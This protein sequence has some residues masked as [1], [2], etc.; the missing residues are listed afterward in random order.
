MA[1]GSRGI[2]VAANLQS[3]P[4]SGI[5]AVGDAADPKG[6]PLILVAAKV[7]ASNILK[8]GE[9]VPD[10]AGIPTTVF[11][12]PELVKVG[13]LEDESSSHGLDIDVKYTDTS[14]WFFQYR[15][16]ETTGAAKILVDWSTALI[17]GPTCWATVTPSWSTR[18]A[19]P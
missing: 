5:Y 10:Y 17:V 18:S 4:H 15:V 9:S 16:G 2:D 6:K 13:V 19:L 3:V 7:A 12:I 14:G 1:Y 11:T 8:S